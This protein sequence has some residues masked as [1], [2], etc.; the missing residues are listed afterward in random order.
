MYAMQLVGRSKLFSWAR[1]AFK[2]LKR[3][4]PEPHWKELS[5]KVRTVACH[6][7]AGALVLQRIE[8]GAS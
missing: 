8:S 3:K 4:F 2:Q 5:W 7:E 1:R 6:P